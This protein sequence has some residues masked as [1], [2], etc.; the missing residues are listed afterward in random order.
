MAVDTVPI[1]GPSGLPILGNVTDVDID[2]PLQS[3]IRLSDRYGQIYKLKFGKHTLV[4]VSSY[5]LV[6]EVCDDKRFKK[7]IEGDL[8]QLRKVVHDGLF[9]SRGVEEENWGI[10]HRVLMS[11]FGPMSIRG[12]FDEMHE[13][14]TQ[15]AL[16]WA[17]QGPSQPIDV[18]ED[19]TRLTLDTVALCSMGFRFNS[20]YRDGLHPFIAAMYAVLK[21]AGAKSLRILP[22][23]FYPRKE[24]KYRENIALLRSTAL[25]VL[26]SRREDGADAASTDRSDLLSKML[27]GVDLKTGRKMTDESI[28]DNLIT[29]LIAGHETT[30]ATLSFAMYQILSRPDVYHKLQQEVDAVVGT[31]PVLIDHVAKLR[32]LSAVLR[33]TLRHSSPIPAF[34]REAIKDEVIGGKYAVK[35][36]EQIICLLSK[37]HFDRA[38]YGSDVREFNPERMA[39]DKFDR[40]MKDYPHAWSP[41]GT[42]MRSCIGRPFA[43]QETT[44]ALAVLIQ[45]FNFVMDDPSYRLQ[46]QETLTIK[47]KKFMVRA[48]LRDRLTPSRLETRLASA[49]A[50]EAPTPSPGVPAGHKSRHSVASTSTGHVDGE[51]APKLVILY[52]SNAGTC[53]FMAQRLASSAAAKGYKSSVDA[54]DTI[55]GSMPKN[56]PVI[57]ITSSYEGEPPH[58]AAHF[59]HW[60]QTL[61]PGA[62]KHV[63]YAVYGCGHSDWVH[64]F[65]KVPKL[66]DSTLETLGASRL[67]PLHSTDAK[68]RDMFSDFEAWEDDVLWP[69]ILERFARPSD[70]ATS[71]APGLALSFS[72]PRASVLHQSVE[73]ATVVAARRLVDQSGGSQEKRH[74]ELRLPANMPYSAGDYL[75]VLPHNPKES[76]SR[77]LRR[78][79]FPRDAYVTISSSSPTTLPTGMSLPVAEILSSYVELGQI[80]TKRDLAHLCEM[81]K[82]SDEIPQLK[83]LVGEEFDTVVKAGQ[84]SVLDV[85]EKFPALCVPFHEFLQMLPPMRLRQYSVSS[86]S[87]FDPTK[88]SLTYGVVNESAVSG[89]GRFIGVA[90]SYLSSLE[91][92]E[93]IQISVRPA[94]SGFHLPENQEE[95]P[96][97]CIGAGTGLAPFRAFIQERATLQGSGRNLAPAILFYGCR[98]P[99][100]DDL[101]RDEFDAWEKSGVVKIFRAYSG[102]KE[103]SCGCPYVQDRIWHERGSITNMWEKGARFYVCGSGKMAEGVKGV[104]VKIVTEEYEK[105]GEPVTEEEAVGH[106]ERI[107]KER[108]CM[109]VFD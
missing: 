38:A 15:L 47:P 3:F 76:V 28:I 41:F 70:A 33:E 42:G 40:L 16:K 20:Y 89:T 49:F 91:P 109:D 68:D 59:T 1:P 73:E 17:R 94:Q 87:L 21:E 54:L 43:W 82:E 72:T 13:I 39:D 57:I 102:D 46:I 81:N 58:N 84:L 22:P 77:A 6:H 11:A 37:S 52:G 100:S 107:R 30:A 51:S 104:L 34:A 44:L 26:E 92:G 79:H 101:Y 27:N 85:L 74:I 97:V 10:A 45:N 50:G 103:A 24:E 14:A 32:Y 66:I 71:S 95:T 9:T 25:E 83:R 63:S 60:I 18:G 98:N 19:F 12:M 106:F 5:E 108:Y 96:I 56:T 67:G 88:V 86:S 90:S 93:K 23:M 78:F 64:T 31:G 75:A 105:A 8:E 35:A 55:R 4:V 69:S 99:L 7:S 80:A 62:M 36:G 61:E 65:Q 29:F 2:H 53:Q 48:I